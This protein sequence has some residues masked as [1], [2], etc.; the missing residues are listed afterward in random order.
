MRDQV[1]VMRVNGMK[2]ISIDREICNFTIANPK[3]VIVREEEEEEEEERKS[4]CSRI[5]LTLNR[6]M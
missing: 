1:I 3:K 4:D 6:S 2:A 5:T